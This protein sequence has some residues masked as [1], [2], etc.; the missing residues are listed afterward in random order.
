M[1]ILQSRAAI[2]EVKTPAK[3]SA[4]PLERMSESNLPTPRASL[5]QLCTPVQPTAVVS[6]VIDDVPVVNK[7]FPVSIGFSN[8]V[9]EPAE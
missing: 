7:G 4:L 6:Q 8:V 5:P 3:V 1:K 2:T 9:P